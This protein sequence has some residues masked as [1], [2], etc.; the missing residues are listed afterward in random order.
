M[1]NGPKNIYFIDLPPTPEKK[2][3]MEDLISVLEEIKNGHVMSTMYGSGRCLLMPHPHIVI[4]SNQALNY[5]FLS[6]DRWKVYEITDKLILKP[7]FV[8]KFDP[9]FLT[10]FNPPRLELKKG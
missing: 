10:Q 5:S 6:K 7:H 3:K 9:Q 8:E 4:F 1:N 2:D